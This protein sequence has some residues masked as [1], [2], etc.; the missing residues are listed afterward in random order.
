M[1]QYSITSGTTQLVLPSQKR[2][3]MKKLHASTRISNTLTHGYTKT[4]EI[5]HSQGQ[6]SKPCTKQVI[7][8]P[9]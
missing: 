6:S 7:H 3:A 9:C 8:N 1:N 5:T 4:M 2:L